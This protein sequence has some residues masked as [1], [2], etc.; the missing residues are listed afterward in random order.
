MSNISNDNTTL[1]RTIRIDQK[2]VT[3]CHK[4]L[5][6]DKDSD[7]E[8][9]VDNIN[10]YLSYYSD[11][12]E[13][14]TIEISNKDQ[15]L[16]F[17][18][19][20]PDFN[21]DPNGYNLHNEQ[22]WRYG[23][24]GIWASNWTAWK[25]FLNTDKDYLIMMEDDLQVEDNFMDLLIKYLNELPQEWDIFYYYCP[26]DQ[27]NKYSQSFSTSEHTSVIYQDWSSACHVISK[28]GA[29]K[30]LSTSSTGINLPLDWHVFRQK[31]K[32][33]A[34][35][36]KPEVEIGCRLTEIESTFQSKQSRQIL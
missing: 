24:V 30:L 22:G 33:K 31:N 8:P 2:E 27:F 4:V 10:E 32:F 26:A 6:L 7:R 13:T 29:E 28:I 36:I 23:E 15:Y 14:P 21:I 3:F 34:F 16:N 11:I 35:T 12:L 17:T 20:N 18:N 5:H 9:F 25:N 19:S 1:P